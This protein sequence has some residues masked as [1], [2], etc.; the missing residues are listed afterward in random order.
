MT[1][2]NNNIIQVNGVS[3]SFIV[4][5]QTLQILKNVSMSVGTGD[6][7]VIFGPSGCGKSTLL[8]GILGLEGPTTGNIFV[9]N[10]D[11]YKKPSED[12]ISEFRK[13]HIGMVF[14]QPNWIKSLNV[15]ENVAFPLSL[16]GLPK[17]KTLESAKKYLEIVGMLDWAN[18]HPSEL[19]SG[20][21]QKVALARG[22]IND[23]EIIVADEPTGNLDFESGREVL[24]LLQ[25][26]NDSGKTIVMVTH[27]LEYLSYAKTAVKMFDG[28]IEGIFQ[29]EE[30]KAM[31]L[32]MHYKRGGLHSPPTKS[33]LPAE[34][35]KT[36][37]QKEQLLT[38]TNE[39]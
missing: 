10:E 34:I 3:K 17:D 39:L 26:L 24:E 11:L 12:E 22:L 20:Q 8:H 16:V 14:Q 2:S 35:A 33:D 13:K 37:E 32:T 23:P 18:R 29:G 28:E 27:D 36:E 4:G 30:K 19:S 9:L 1:D 38:Q 21:Q 15:V 5:E 6:F 7:L 25:R 31:T